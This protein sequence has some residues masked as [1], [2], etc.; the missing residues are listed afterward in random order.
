MPGAESARERV[1]SEARVTTLV[2]ITQNRRFLP[3]VQI[4]SFT[5]RKSK[6]LATLSTYPQGALAKAEHRLST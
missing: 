1:G 2:S 4:R 6:S 5:L 3:K